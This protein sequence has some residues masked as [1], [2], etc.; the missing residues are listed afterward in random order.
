MRFINKLLSIVLLSFSLTAAALATVGSWEEERANYTIYF[1]GG[2]T[3]SLYY[4][5]QTPRRGAEI[6]NVEWEYFDFD[7]GFANQK[8][9]LCYRKPHSGSFSDFTC[10]DI[11]GNSTGATNH[12]DGLDARGTMVL[13]YTLEGGM[14]YAYWD[15]SVKNKIKVTYDY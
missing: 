11:S 5:L 3:D 8:V 10:T 14:Y 6:I 7:N 15:N 1:D 13:R 2:F 9:D 12:F 4:N